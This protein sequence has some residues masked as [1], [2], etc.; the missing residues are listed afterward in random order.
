MGV[1]LGEVNL[2]GLRKRRQHQ[3]VRHR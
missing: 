2:R 3:R 1:I